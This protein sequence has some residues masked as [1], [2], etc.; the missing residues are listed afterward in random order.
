MNTNNDPRR[1]A[2]ALWAQQQSALSLKPD[3][4]RPASAD[5]SFRRYFRIDSDQ[6]E[7]PSVILMDA[8]PPKED[9]RPFIDIAGRLWRSG[10]NVPQILAADVETGFLA[11][12]DLGNTTF[13]A[14][15]T[16]A[17]RARCT[18]R[19]GSRWCASR[20]PLIRRAS[21]HTTVPA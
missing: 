17:P 2:L 12:T 7:H 11:L 15:W 19:P 3:T 9:V 8:P 4:L 14:F 1:E 18:S 13:W 6:P 5:A 10:V 16:N 20:R 21:R